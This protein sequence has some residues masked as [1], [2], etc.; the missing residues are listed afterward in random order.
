MTSVGRGERFEPLEDG[1][2]NRPNRSSG[3]TAD[4]RQGRPKQGSDRAEA[5][6]TS[7]FERIEIEAYIF[8]RVEDYSCPGRVTSL[9][10]NSR[11]PGPVSTTRTSIEILETIKRRDGATITEV[12]DELRIAPSTVHRHFGTLLDQGLVVY[13]DGKYRVGLRFLD[14]GIYARQALSFYDIAKAQVDMLANE[15]GEK[16]RLIATEDGLSIL[17]YRAMGDHPLNTSARIGSRRPL[18][19]LAAGKSILAR[20]QE[21]EIDWIIDRH[22]LAGRT[23]S[24]ITNREDL[25][26]ELETVRQRGYGFNYSESIEGLNAVGTA[27]QDENGRPLGAL[28]VSGPANRL[29]GDVLERELPELLLGAVNEIEINLKYA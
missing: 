18:H 28:S 13:R 24:T 5:G 16:A 3:L 22:G 9:Y 23:E 21:D 4:V 6:R 29:K 2:S 26:A 20:L 17:L 19:Q 8:D 25:L 7:A 14:F 10:D 12:A 27:F 15:T 11:K 1:D